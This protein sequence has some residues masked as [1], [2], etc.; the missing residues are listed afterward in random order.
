MV[1]Q[2]GQALSNKLSRDTD[3]F[4]IIFVFI[5]IL[6]D[7]KQNTITQMF[8]GQIPLSFT[9]ACCHLN[10][11]M[12]I[13]C[14]TVKI[15]PRPPRFDVSRSHAARHKHPVGLSERGLSSPALR[16]G[17]RTGNTQ[18]GSNLRLRKSNMRRTMP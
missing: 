5:K 13:F 3:P 12:M 2:N 8:F 11:M 10:L 18:Q 9:S 6:T 1:T 16:R 15:K 17:C 14:T 7:S 4:I